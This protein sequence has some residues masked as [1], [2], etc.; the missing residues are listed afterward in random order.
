MKKLIPR[1]QWKQSIYKDFRTKNIYK[2]INSLKL[3]PDIAEIRNAVNSL[4]VIYAPY[5][6]EVRGV[7]YPKTPIELSGKPSVFFKPYSIVS[8]LNWALSTG[9]WSLDKAKVVFGNE[10]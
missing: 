5:F 3:L 9:E 7:M 10:T 2:A 4:S 1:Y 8:E 6:K